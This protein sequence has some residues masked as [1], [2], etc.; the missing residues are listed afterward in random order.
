MFKAVFISFFFLIACVS[1][2]AQVSKKIIFITAPNNHDKGEHEYK[3]GCY[4]LADL[5]NKRMPDLSTTVYENGWPSNADAFDSVAAL[6]LYCNGGERHLLLSHLQEMDALMQRGVGLVAIHN[7]IEAPKG[8]TGNLFL[9]WL[10]GYFETWYSVNPRW[11]ANVNIVSSH[12]ISQDIQP[13]AI[14][15]EWYYHIRF[16]DS[17]K[18][19]FPIL[20]AIPPM[21]SLQETD[22]AYKGN[23]LVRKAVANKESQVLCWAY[24]RPNDGR[25]IGFTGGH[26]H[27]NWGN[28]YFRKIVLNAILWV[29]HIDMP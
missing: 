24:N 13:F 11:K 5:L 19:V 15:D 28:A 14:K 10:G 25:S 6:V 23:P 8:E 9:D 17:M 21:S 2:T 3:K 7:A 29:S 4:L 1:I 26:Y 20:E 16:A 18:N 22:N 27:K 12:E